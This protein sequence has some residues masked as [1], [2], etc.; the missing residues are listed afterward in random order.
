MG[1]RVNKLSLSVNSPELGRKIIYTSDHSTDE[2]WFMLDA[3]VIGAIKSPFE[4]RA[5]IVMAEVMRG[6]EGPPHTADLRLVG[7]DMVNGFGRK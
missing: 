5:A 2:Y 4:R 6:Y 1:P 7:A 3:S